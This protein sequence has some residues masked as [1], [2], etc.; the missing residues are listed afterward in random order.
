MKILKDLDVTGKRVFLRADLDVP[1]ESTNDERLTT[2]AESATRLQNIKP[3]VDYLLEHG[4]TQIIIAGHIDRPEKPDPK[5]STKQLVELL[6]KIL[7]QKIEFVQ[8]FTGPVSSFLPASARSNKLDPNSDSKSKEL[9]AD[10]NP[11]TAATPKI[12]LFENLRFWPGEV[13]DSPELARELAALADI[14][15]NDAFGNCHRAHASMIGVPKLLP[16]AAGLHLQLE[17]EKLTELM[18]FPKK[19]YVAVI[20]GEKIETKVPVIHNLARVAD[21][22][23]VGGYLVAEIRGK[24]FEMQNFGT[25]VDIGTLTPDDEDLDAQS[26]TKFTAVI[27]TAA[28]VVW[29]G[30]MGHF[31]AGF[32]KASVAVAQAIIESGAYSVVGGGETTQ[33][34]AKNNLLSK[35]SF[36]SS[37]GGAMLEFLAG[38]KLPGIEA[39]T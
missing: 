2:N 15:V 1:L 10:G 11:S 9:R 19:P 38:K 22:V 13:G 5:L 27:S 17:V 21:T 6:E 29:N 32:V 18:T 12:L 20:G 14:Y 39:L 16:H 33:F 28:T 4:A 31:E 25:N 37:G 24:K 35:F 8:D 7:G 3:T 36:V 30:P 34:L 26:T 23:L